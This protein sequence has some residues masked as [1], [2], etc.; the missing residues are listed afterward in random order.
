MMIDLVVIGAGSA[1]YVAAIKAAQLGKQVIIIEKDKIG[2]TCLNKG[3]IPTKTLLH[4]AQ[5]VK[6]QKH[7]E[8][9]GLQGNITFDQHKMNDHKNNI[10]TKL[11]DGIQSLLT[12]NNITTIKGEAIIIDEH[13]VEVNKKLIKTDY[14][15]L[16]TGATTRKLPN[17]YSSD[18][19]LD[20]GDKQFKEV[21]IIGGGVI[22]CELASLYS[23]LGTKVTI[24]EALPRLLSPFDKE[25]S[26]NLSMIF[27][28]DGITVVTNVNNIKIDDHHI[29]YTHK[30]KEYT[31]ECDA[32]ISAIGRDAHEIKSK[33]S[34][35]FD[36][37]YLVNEHFQTSIPSIYAVGDCSST[38]QLA[39]MASAQAQGAIEHMFNES[40]TINY[41]NVPSVVYTSPEIASVGQYNTSN[42]DYKVGKYTLNGH[43]YTLIHQQ[44]RSFVK[45]VVDTK[46][47]ILVSATL[48]CDHAG[49]LITLLTHFIKDKRPISELKELIYPHPSFVEAISEAIHQLD[50]TAIHIMPK[51]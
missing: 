19:I 9:L 40:I 30:D 26:Q 35:T 17:T 10:V 31:L 2:G 3:C 32:I 36:K 25:V 14:I 27:K 37:R 51:K 4:G 47:Q 28:R 45:L 7:F 29:T 23:S 8:T 20:F 12:G 50:D 41:Q 5:L 34:I 11:S 38:I 44:Q 6:S 42:P 39:H 33:I 13:T 46:Q 15:L 49:D 48:M 22:G 18:D 24:L 21:V 16:A 1:G 43:G